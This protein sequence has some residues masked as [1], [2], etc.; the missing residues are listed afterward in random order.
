MKILGYFNKKK[1]KRRIRVGYFDT[2]LWAT[3][4]V[5]MLFLLLCV[6]FMVA[7]VYYFFEVVHKGSSTQSI[8]SKMVGYLMI[9]AIFYMFFQSI[10]KFMKTI[11]DRLLWDVKVIRNDVVV[12]DSYT[13][14]QQRLYQ[15]IRRWLIYELQTI[16]SEGVQ[17]QLGKI[18]WLQKS[19][20]EVDDL[21]KSQLSLSDLRQTNYVFNS[22]VF[23]E[24]EVQEKRQEFTDKGFEDWLVDY[25]SKYLADW[26][27]GE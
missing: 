6:S 25:I 18:E 8:Q 26:Q 5:D 1:S 2:I 27:P 19:L 15:T 17:F 20:L 10:S 23:A 14:G 24:R 7:F 11:Y 22:K 21:E 9:T 13:V 12:H 16:H 3:L 4:L